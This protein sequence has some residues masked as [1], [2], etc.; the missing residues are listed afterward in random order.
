M[1]ANL[2]TPPANLSVVIPALNEAATVAGVVTQMLSSPLVREVIVVDNGSSDETSLIA[3]RAKARVISC[4]IRGLGKAIKEGLRVATGDW[5]LKIDA[6]IQNPSHTWIDRLI[7]SHQVDVGLIKGWWT[8]ARD[9]MPVTNLVARPSLK[10]FFPQLENLVM[11]LSGIYLFHRNNTAW[12]SLPDNWA[13]DVALLL[14]THRAGLRIEQV[15]LGE[16]IDTLKPVSNYT[17]MAFEL[18][19]YL[20]RPSESNPSRSYFFCLAHPDDAELWCGGTMIKLLAMGH[21][22]SLLIAAAEEDRK[23][24]AVDASKSLE[25]LSLTF[26][27]QKEFEL[28]DERTHVEEVVRQVRTTRPL[29][30]VT[31]HRSDPNLDHR[32]CY[33]LTMTALMRL[34]RHEAPKRIYMCDSYYSQMNHHGSF[35]P[36]TFVDVSDTAEA[37]YR[38][39]A[40][41]NSQDTKFWIRVVRALDE[42]NGLRAGV[43]R[44]EAFET[45]PS[46]YATSQDIL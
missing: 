31:H 34:G 22:V 16:V 10:R 33:S 24:E 30:I 45:L 11:P 21:K 17:N 15:F 35:Q 42:L 28:L 40:H 4:P 1:P 32:R 44:A 18:I 41:H 23:R 7:S 46:L 20:S 19:D 12:D 2:T 37:K 9:P 26:L 27:G 29:A 8:N 39:I 5:V 25:R 3:E 36:D 6:Y 14:Q 43:V 38:L 13:F